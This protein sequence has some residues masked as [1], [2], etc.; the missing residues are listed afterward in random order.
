MVHNQALERRTEAFD[1]RRGRP[2]RKTPAIPSL[3]RWGRRASV[4]ALLTSWAA[5]ASAQQPFGSI[6]GTVTDPTGAPLSAATVTVT[7]AATQVTQT[8]ET[9]STGDYSLP[10]LANGTYTIKAER[11][12]F[13]ASVTSRELRAAQTLRVDVRLQLGA[14]E[15]A[16]E[17][18][19]SAIALQTDTTGVATTIDAKAIN[20]LPL[21][22]RTFA[23][24]ATLVPGVAPQVSANI[25]TDRK[26]GSIGTPFAIT[27]SGFSAVQ[28]SFA[29]DGVPAMDLDSYNFAFSPSLD[30]IGQFRVQTSTYS[31]AY[32]G[33]PGAHVD[34]ATKSG[35]NALHG[36]AWEFNRERRARRAQLLQ[37][38]QAPAESESVR[39]EPGR[40]DSQ[41]RAVLLRELGIRP[42]GPG[43]HGAAGVAPSHGLSN[44]RFLFLVAERHRHHRSRDRTAV[45]GQPDTCRSYRS[46]CG[47]VPG[48]HAGAES[49]LQCAG[50]EQ[51]PQPEPRHA[52][53]RR[54]ARRTPRLSPFPRRCA[55]GAV[56]LRRA[57]GPQRGRRCSATTRPSIRRTATTWPPAGRTPSRRRS[58]RTSSWDGTGSSSTRCSEPRTSRNTTS[59]AASWSSRWWPATPSTTGRRTSRPATRCSGCV[60]M[61]RA[62]A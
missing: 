10:Y 62:T 51:L 31:S 58:R 33:A 39:G 6:V 13:R 42:P 60:T 11:S 2:S 18:S 44:R 5:A 37:H 25:T 1:G 29:Y 49:R 20:D 46:R 8:V 59:R 19:A 38:D 36:T 4:L 48:L 55:L 43:H 47:A 56:H 41:E 12:G 57:H 24:L 7:H 9:G 40:P 23:Q 21:N 61:A 27:A 53:E 16:I 45:P 14:F 17:V 3:Q 32:G 28:N 15:E 30:A 50:R 52:D 26:R 34:V 54:P 35:T 22:G